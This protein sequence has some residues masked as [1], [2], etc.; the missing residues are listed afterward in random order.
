MRKIYFVINPQ[1][2]NGYCR[3]VWLEVERELI[4]RKLSYMAFFTEYGGHAKEIAQSLVKKAGDEEIVVVAVGGDGTLNEVMNGVANHNNVI[5]GCIP[6]GSGND[7]SRGFG[8]P[9]QPLDALELILRKINRKATF[10]DIGK[11]SVQQES[12]VYFINNMGVGFDALI[13]K[14][15]NRSKLK[16]TLNRFSLG[17]LVYAF[18]L[19]KKLFTYKC[20]DLQ[21]KIDGQ[22]YSFDSTWFVTVSNQPYYGGGMKISP[23]AVPN[24]GL[25]NITVVHKLSKIKLLLVFITVFWGG[26]VSFKE[27]KSLKGK[28]ITIHSSEPLFSHADGEL[29]GQTPLQIQACQHV[30]PIIIRGIEDVEELKEL[31]SSDC[32]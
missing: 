21:L 6:G 31:S 12:K 5:L 18:L 27:V 24:D 28:S 13:S 10:I 19:L 4:S 22:T 16:Q 20:T 11:I 26:H 29:I 7:F 9:K 32:H 1:A 15:A 14:E 2:K 17:S 23:D 3:K 25:L 30:L 8:I